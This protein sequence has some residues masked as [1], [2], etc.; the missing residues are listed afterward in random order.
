MAKRKFH[1][2]RYAKF[3]TVQAPSTTTLVLLLLLAGAGAG[4]FAGIII[5]A[6]LL[7]SSLT[8]VLVSGVA[9][10]ILVVSLPALLTAAALK[11]VRR[12]MLL[13]HALVATLLITL[14]YAVLLALGSSL[15][16]LV[17][18]ASLAYLFLLVVNAGI[19]GYWLVIG[20]FVT[21]RSKS[22]IV[23]AV[24]QPVLNILFYLPL[25][26][27]IL[28][29]GATL[30][31]AMTKLA[32]GM[33]VFLVAGY[34]FLYMVD[35]P[36]KRHM[37]TSGISIFMNLA[38]EWLF[39]IAGDVSVIGKSASS[40]TD[41]D[42]EMLVLRGK[43]NYKAVFVNPDIHFGPF[44]G[45][46]GSIATRQIGRL[47]TGK[48]SASPFV[49]HSTVDMRNNPVGTGQVYSLSNSISRWLENMGGFSKA[50]GSVSSGREGACSVLDVS[51]GNAGLFFLSKAPMVTEDIERRVG[52]RLKEIAERESGG[53]AI[54][55]DAHNSRFESAGKN[56]LAGVHADSGYVKMYESAV[57]AAAKAN[58]KRHPL[59]FGSAHKVLASALK[60]PIDMGDGYT[61]V[62]VFAYG[63]RRF[64]LVYFDANNMLPGF[65]DD[66][67]SHIRGKYR[68]QAELCT[69][70]THSLNAINSSASNCLG[71]QTRAKSMIEVLD[72]LID[73]ALRSVEPVSY[74]YKRTVMEDFAVWGENAEVLI[75]RASREVR[76][77]VKY[78][79]PALVLAA[80]V[81]AA[82]V[83]Y[84]V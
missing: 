63:R 14:P 10:G 50:Y 64:C 67:I 71:R 23:I 42:V 55:V 60:W 69:T 81:V 61:S 8:Q 30:T 36:T 57:A 33:L 29:I 40:T 79:T 68:M 52:A 24:L 3:F 32:A 46:G 17:G 78:A 38:S 74:A 58:S 16:V 4:G 12:R 72:P 75:E 82:W 5:H 25:S 13:K 43:N 15:F 66:I 34:A 70:D 20:R 37:A 11:M 9:A 21:G 35:R 31:V 28:G 41:L 22:I 76:N 6:Q 83:I 26:S 48:F 19:Y 80:F 47:I 18:Y 62:G 59:S 2:M 56:E 1:L 54:V 77:R 73:D 7:S 51:V 53:R 45:A 39:D 44:H 65:R 49:L 84:V 27:Y